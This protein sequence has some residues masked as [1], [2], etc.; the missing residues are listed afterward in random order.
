MCDEIIDEK[1][2]KTVPTSSNEKKVTCKTQNLY[3]LL[4]F[5]LIPIAL[6]VAVSIYCYPIKY[7]N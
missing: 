3:V 4:A 1:K 5:F 2:K 6:L 7:S